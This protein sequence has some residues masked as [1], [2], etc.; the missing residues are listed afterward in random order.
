MFY[1]FS[2]GAFADAGLFSQRF[3]ANAVL[4]GITDTAFEYQDW[5]SADHACF[6]LFGHFFSYLHRIVFETFGQLSTLIWAGFS[7]TI[8]KPY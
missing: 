4:A 5:L 6:F 3:S 8:S 2:V 7:R 1:E